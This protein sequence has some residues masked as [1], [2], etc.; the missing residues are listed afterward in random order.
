M[1]SPFL[2]EGIDVR[3]ELLWMVAQRVQVP[4]NGQ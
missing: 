1:L 3:A 2:E 4:N